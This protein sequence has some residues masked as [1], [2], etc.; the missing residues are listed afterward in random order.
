MESS[1]LQ[2]I[3]SAWRI[4]FDAENLSPAKA[5]PRLAIT[6]DPNITYI[7]STYFSYKNALW[8]S[9]L[10]KE[11]SLYRRNSWQENNNVYFTRIKLPN[12][13]FFYNSKPIFQ[14]SFSSDEVKLLAEH[15]KT[16]L[17][18]S[19]CME[20]KDY[21]VNNVPTGK[22][23]QKDSCCLSM[24]FWSED[25]LYCIIVMFEPQFPHDLFQ[26]E[27]QKRQCVEQYEHYLLS[28]LRERKQIKNK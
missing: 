16:F 25:E 17:N 24:S 21:I 5:S 11:C 20:V 14:S 1:T 28:T 7:R 13:I 9:T 4:C 12:P 6:D 10:K 3:F 27:E 23:S 18:A 2:E 26:V 8:K 22:S 15:V 19:N